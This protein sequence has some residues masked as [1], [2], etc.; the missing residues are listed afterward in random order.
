MKPEKVRSCRFLFV[1]CMGLGMMAQITAARE[2]D[3][4][5]LYI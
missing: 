3:I 2:K 4:D 1:P 5:S